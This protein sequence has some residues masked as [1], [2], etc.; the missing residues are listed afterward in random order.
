MRYEEE[1]A[2]LKVLH[3]ATKAHEAK[4]T[5]CDPELLRAAAE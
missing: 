3:E 2:G 5:D 4:L 1:D